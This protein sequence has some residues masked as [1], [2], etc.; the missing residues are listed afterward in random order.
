MLDIMAIPL[1]QGLYALVDGKDYEWLSK[2]KWYILKDKYTLYAVRHCKKKP[3][4]YVKVLMHRQILNVPKGKQ[5]DHRNHYG[6]DNRR[7]NLRSCTQS[8]NNH[9]R[10]PQKAG[11]SKFQ[12][13]CWHKG[14]KKWMA[15]IKCNNKKIY[16][17]YFDNEIDAG[18]VY[19][20]K[21]K[22]LYGDF[23]YT[24]F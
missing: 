18:R 15:Q 23:A 7:Q 8:E 2:Y 4:K 11:T 20:A 13:V 6:L 17:G 9:N 24:N 19:D 21:A 16:L 1:A 22:E 5:T 3:H 12:G 10:R 14:R